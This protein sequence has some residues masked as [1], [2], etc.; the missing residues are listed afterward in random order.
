MKIGRA[1]SPKKELLSIN[2]LT[3]YIERL[4]MSLVR[5]TILLA[6]IA[7]HY[8]SFQYNFGMSHVINFLSTFK[9][10][11]KNLSYEQLLQKLDNKKVT[12][13]NFYNQ[14]FVVFLR[15]E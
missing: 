2:I 6:D 15:I 4:K 3:I 1:S 5:G 12:R 8:M 10:S 13:I 9:I 14:K 7:I 11:E